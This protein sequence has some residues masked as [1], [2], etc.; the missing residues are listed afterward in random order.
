VGILLSTRF[1]TD[2]KSIHDG[3]LCLSPLNAT[4]SKTRPAITNLQFS[5]QVPIVINRL[6]VE[7]NGHPGAAGASTRAVFTLL[8][9]DFISNW[10]F[11]GEKP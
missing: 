8:S 11:Y 3:A 2:A 9:R 6:D 1:F 5:Y 7:A 10:K 4:S